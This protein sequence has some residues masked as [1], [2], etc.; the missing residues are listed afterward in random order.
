MLFLV[1]TVV[2]SGCDKNFEEFDTS[3]A[4]TGNPSSVSSLSSESLAGEILLKWEVPADSNYQYLQVS[5]YDYLTEENITNVASVYCDTMLIEDTRAKYGN[6]EFTFQ[7]FNSKG[8]GSAE[9]TLSAVSGAAEATVTY[10]ATEITLSSDQLSTNSQEPSEGALENIIDGDAST[11]Y[12]SIWST[13]LVDFPLYIQVDLD[14][15]IDDFQFYYQNRSG[16]QYCPDDLQVQISE[17]GE[18]WETIEEIS[19]GLPSG[20]GSEY[21]SE[22]FE[23]GHTFTHFRFNVVSTYDD[24]SYFNMAEFKFYDV[25]ISIDDPEE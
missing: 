6:Y 18:N 15:A 9:Q 20:S 1:A 10:D 3:N 24:A 13:T 8:D 5:Y 22:V 16:S 7:T 11:F 17:D 14:E 12:H 4:I 23:P 2:F 25:D 19:S 21:T